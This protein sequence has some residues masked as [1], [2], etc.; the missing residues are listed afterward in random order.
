MS[1]ILSC[2]VDI[3][4]WTKISNILVF[5]FF[6]RE[7]CF[8]CIIN[9]HNFVHPYS[10]SR[11]V[12][13][14]YNIEAMFSPMCIV[15]TQQPSFMDLCVFWSYAYPWHYS[16]LSF[17]LLIVKKTFLFKRISMHIFVINVYIYCSAMRV[18]NKLK[19]WKVKRGFVV[20]WRTHTSLLRHMRPLL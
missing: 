7:I 6:G 3:T 5:A 1:S 14:V 2:L 18:K 12:I 11:N 15:Y 9:R 16:S 13:S 17:H 10:Y 20:S 4:L 19:W 8:P